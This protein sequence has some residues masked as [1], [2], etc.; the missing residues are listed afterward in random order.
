MGF[1]VGELASTGRQPAPHPPSHCFNV[2]Q[3]E[4]PPLRRDQGAYEDTARGLQ[5]GLLVLPLFTV[6]VM[7]WNVIGIVL[8]YEVWSMAQAVVSWMCVM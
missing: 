6:I 2:G 8:Q 1:A 7:G 4:V 3:Q 5:K